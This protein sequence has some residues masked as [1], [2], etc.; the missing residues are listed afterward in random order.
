MRISLNR[1]VRRLFGRLLTLGWALLA[2]LVAISPTRADWI[3][4]TGAETA[5]N[6]AEITVFDD[7][8]EV[9]LEVYVGDLKTF[10][11][12]IP[13]DWV[14]DLK[15]DRPPLAERLRRFSEQGLSFVTDTGETLRAELRLAE[16]RLRKDRFSPFAGMIPLHLG[17]GRRGPGGQAGGVC[18]TG[19][20]VRRD[21][22]E[23]P[24]HEPAA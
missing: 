9:A 18:G 19:L 21:G 12:L 15:V 1:L 16:P 22:T 2:T 17:Q 13:D 4:L 5:P 20:P 24:D 6:I 14:K 11:A 8:V 3:N 10:E 23:D 7:R